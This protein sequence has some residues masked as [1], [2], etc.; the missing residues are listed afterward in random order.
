MESDFTTAEKN[1]LRIRGFYEKNRSSS[2]LF[3]LIPKPIN[4]SKEGGN[5]FFA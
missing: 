3:T 1:N 4:L 2:L 5:Q